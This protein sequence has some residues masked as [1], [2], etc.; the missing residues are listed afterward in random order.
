MTTHEVIEYKPRS[1]KSSMV[2]IAVA[3]INLIIMMFPPI[4]LAMTSGGAGLAI[5]YFLGLS[6]ILIVS[7]LI[8]NA[9]DAKTDEMSRS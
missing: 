8:L 7:L 6:I 2:Y 5:G 1:H 9:T 4:Y 3:T